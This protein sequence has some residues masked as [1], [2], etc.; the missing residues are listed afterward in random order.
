MTQGGLFIN[1]NVMCC[2]RSLCVCVGCV[3]LQHTH[4]CNLLTL[5]TCLNHVDSDCQKR[6]ITIL[7][8]VQSFA[9]CFF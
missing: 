9:V 1:G 3:P 6:K 7:M 5:T 8:I 4:M 2:M